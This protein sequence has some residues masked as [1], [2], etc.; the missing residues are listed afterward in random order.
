MSGY[1]AADQR[2]QRPIQLQKSNGQFR[3]LI[4]KQVTQ[5]HRSQED[6]DTA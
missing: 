6:E 5:T 4:Q 2:I 3:S 1:K